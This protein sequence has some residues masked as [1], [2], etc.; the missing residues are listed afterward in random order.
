MAKYRAYQT[1]EGFTV[2]YP[3]DVPVEDAAADIERRRQ[4][5]DLRPEQPPG[6]PIGPPMED[7]GPQEQQP[8]GGPLNLNM[9]P[10]PPVQEFEEE[11]PQPQMYEEAEQGPPIGVLKGDVQPQLA[12]NDL[13]AARIGAGLQGALFEG[14]DEVL[15][16]GQAALDTLTGS[17]PGQPIAA[18]PKQGQQPTGFWSKYDYYRDRARALDERLLGERPMEAYGARIGAG[19]ASGLGAL[20][21]LSKMAIERVAPEMGKRLAASKIVP[22]AGSTTTRAAAT[23]GD[24]AVDSALQGSIAGGM[25]GFNSGQSNDP[26][27][28]IVEDAASRLMSGI[29]GA[30]I[31]AGIG[32]VLPPALAAVGGGARYLGQAAFPSMINPQKRALDVMAQGI[33][34][35]LTVSPQMGPNAPGPVQAM[36]PGG[37]AIQDV[38]LADVSPN[39]RQMA[40]HV[41]RSGRQGGTEVSEFLTKRQEGDPISG[42]AGGGMWTQMLRHVREVIGTTNPTELIRTLAKRRSEAA[43]PAYNKAFSHPE[44][45]IAELNEMLM[46]D[47][48]RAGARLGAKIMKDLG[49]LPEDFKLPK[50]DDDTQTLPLK[51]WHVVKMGLDAQHQTLLKSGRRLEAA[52]VNSRRERLLDLLDEATDGDYGKARQEYAG[53]SQM[54]EAVEQGQ[55]LFNID[56]SDLSDLMAQYSKSPGMQQLFVAG[57]GKAL[58]EKIT[59][60]GID[61]NSA[62]IMYKS[63]D[64]QMRLGLALGPGMYQNFIKRCMAESEK[65]KSFMELKGSQT[66]SRGNIGEMVEEAIAGGGSA[67]AIVAAA[68]VGGGQG[69]QSLVRPIWGWFTQ[70]SPRGLHQSVKDEIAKMATETD[71]RKQQKIVDGIFAAANRVLARQRRQRMARGARSGATA[72]GATS[73]MQDGRPDTSNMPPAGFKKASDG[74]WYGPDPKRKGAYLKWTPE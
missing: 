14:G 2:Y 53:Y 73:L 56:V 38:T 74:A 39:V 41:A 21:K 34:D 54:M 11:T 51:V 5:G 66:D 32:G 19:L 70:N 62:W 47:R 42:E 23:L 50:I 4:A 36:I 29:G 15:G 12:G 55:D 59:R 43:K 16:F 71:P 46:S 6:R 57:V 61:S 30:G 13:A 25:A 10:Y 52:G 72:I 37:Q 18:G 48:V 22:Q 17:E 31:G 58:V 40:G 60:K 8:P 20:P 26:E 64:V 1:R 9:N 35:D 28:G 44:P 68:G 45:D 65:F 67:E 24:K 69:F 49:E 27:A 33:G 7:F 3:G 63:P